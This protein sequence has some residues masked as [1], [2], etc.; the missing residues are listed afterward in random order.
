MLADKLQCLQAQLAITLKSCR[1]RCCCRFIWQ[2][3]TGI[4]GIV[5]TRTMA[6]ASWLLTTSHSPSVA[7]MRK[8]SLPV[9]SVSKM[10]GSATTYFLRRR[11]PKALDTARQCRATRPDED[12]VDCW[13]TYRQSQQVNHMSQIPT[14]LHQYHTLICYMSEQSGC[15][16]SMLN[17]YT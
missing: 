10:S 6:M 7:I 15:W 1:K 4:V 14:G 5:L 9:S 12:G 2:P 3:R 16:N 13:S 8:V 17:E 11:S